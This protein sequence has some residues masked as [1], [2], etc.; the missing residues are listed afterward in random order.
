MSCPF[1]GA[2]LYFKPGVN[3]GGVLFNC[4]GN[5]CA[6][7]TSAHS[8]CWMEVGES[9]PPDWEACP[10]NPEYPAHAF[11][12]FA[13]D[14]NER[15]RFSDCVSFLVGMQR[16]RA[17]FREVA[18]LA[19][20]AGLEG[21]EFEGLEMGLDSD[22]AF[23][24]PRDTPLDKLCSIRVTY[25]KSPT[26]CGHCGAPVADPSKHACEDAGRKADT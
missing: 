23:S 10:R 26:R 20:R 6:L 9:R 16:S 24:A 19:N 4:G 15:L 22:L 18:Q 1:Y 25:R 12:E 17:E 11:A 13:G 8:P 21:F 3:E 2:S 5:R 14:P 7:I